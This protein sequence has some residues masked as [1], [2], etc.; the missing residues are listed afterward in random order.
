MSSVRTLLVLTACAAALGGLAGAVVIAV[1]GPEPAPAD[2]AHES[3]ATDGDG[4]PPPAEPPV[5]DSSGR[6]RSP[7]APDPGLT[8]RLDAADA[9]VRHALALELLHEGPDALAQA[10]ALR[11]T[12]EAGRDLQSRLVAALDKMLLLRRAND[13]PKLPPHIR[14]RLDLDAF[15]SVVPESLLVEPRI[16]Y[17]EKE[18]EAVRYRR[19]HG[20]AHAAEESLAELE[21]ALARYEAGEIERPDYVQDAA[22]RM[23]GIDA[24]L[25]ELRGDPHRAPAQ[26]R[27][28]EDQ[29][30]RLRP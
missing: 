20:R 5:A 10:R 2:E 6:R 7:R 17:W 8:Q 15:A 11:P 4:A 30:A 14:L 21:L 13:Y 18:I 12:T 1:S 16:A 28:L 23:P 24:W 22:D 19:E 29:V 27:E 3:A 26:V 9:D 25:A